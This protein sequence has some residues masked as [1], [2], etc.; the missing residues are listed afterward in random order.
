MHFKGFH[1]DD[2]NRRTN[3]TQTTG[4]KQTT[5]F[6]FLKMGIEKNRAYYEIEGVQRI[7]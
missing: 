7:N 5:V 6:F 1:D 4:V 3:D 2:N